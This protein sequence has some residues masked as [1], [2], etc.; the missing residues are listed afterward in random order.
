MT[1]LCKRQKTLMTSWIEKCKYWL[2][3]LMNIQWFN[4]CNSSTIMN[5]SHSI[6]K[7]FHASSKK[8]FY[9]VHLFH[10]SYSNGNLRYPFTFLLV[11]LR[12]TFGYPIANTISINHITN[13][14]SIGTYKYFVAKNFWIH[15]L[16]SFLH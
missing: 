12:V 2:Y 8:M 10:E 5:F 3:D 7:V 11:T 15:V 1:N 4:S 6:I 14:H 13:N 9:C 16:H